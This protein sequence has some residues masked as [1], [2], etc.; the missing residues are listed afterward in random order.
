M[1]SPEMTQMA[2]IKAGQMTSPEMTQMAPIKA[3][4]AHSSGAG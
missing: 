2:P 1:T 4:Q 3:G